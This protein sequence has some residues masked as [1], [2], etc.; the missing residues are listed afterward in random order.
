MKKRIL[1]FIIFNLGEIAGA[2]G[3]VMGSYDL[4]NYIGAFTEKTSII[5]QYILSSVM[6]FLAGVLISFI[7]W[8]LITLVKKNWEWAE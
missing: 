2:I 7:V 3:F 4:W 6:T 8:G 1:K 5:G